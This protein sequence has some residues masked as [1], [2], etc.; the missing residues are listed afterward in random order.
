MDFIGSVSGDH[1]ILRI[2]SPIFKRLFESIFMLGAFF[3]FK[4][5]TNFFLIENREKSINELRF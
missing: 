3:I 5:L 2:W 1:G 4:G